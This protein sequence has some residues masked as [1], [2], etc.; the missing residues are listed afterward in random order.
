MDKKL[1][2]N[3]RKYLSSGYAG[4]IFGYTNDYVA[5]LARQKKVCG[6]MVGRTWYVEEESFKNFIQNNT[7]QKNQL[8]KKLSEKRA[9]ELKYFEQSRKLKKII[10][11]FSSGVLLQLKKSSKFF[12]SVFFKKG[13]AGAI[14]FSLVFGI[15]FYKDTYIA[16]AG[17]EKISRGAILAI[18][19]IAEFDT[20]DFITA[21]V[22]ASKNFTACRA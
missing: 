14:A 3:N 13:L 5:R 6:K 4:K 17:F 16:K 18:K 1:I 15:Y 11:S 8:H 22:F 7:A 10:S 2:F 9:D 20:R 21:S 12:N 19:A